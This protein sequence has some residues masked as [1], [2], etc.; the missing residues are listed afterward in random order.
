M[1]PLTTNN[2]LIQLTFDEC[3]LSI[4]DFRQIARIPNLIRVLFLDCDFFPQSLAELSNSKSLRD[5]DIKGGDDNGKVKLNLSILK[6]LSHIR[7]IASM[8]F[9]ECI[10]P[11]YWEPA[12]TDGFQNLVDVNL[13]DCNLTDEE[14]REMLI[15]REGN[16]LGGIDWAH[17]YI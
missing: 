4:D 14:V 8:E 17:N 3:S 2:S 9:E 1:S 6:K 16:N 12:F 5:I 10:S 11:S 13:S 15:K 7:T